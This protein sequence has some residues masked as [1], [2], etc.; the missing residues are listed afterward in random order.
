MQNVFDNVIAIDSMQS[1]RNECPVWNPILQRKHPNWKVTCWLRA[2]WITCGVC[3]EQMTLS[4]TNSVANYPA[5]LWTTV[6]IQHVARKLNAMY[7]TVLCI[8]G[9]A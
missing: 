9:I 2:V 8:L 5:K 6:S 1:F 7:T 4:F 3:V